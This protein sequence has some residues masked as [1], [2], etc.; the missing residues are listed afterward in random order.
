MYPK[1][2]EIMI[3]IKWHGVAKPRNGK[4]LEWRE[5]WR[6]VLGEGKAAPS[7]KDW[8]VEEEAALKNFKDEP[9]SMKETAIGC[10]KVQHKH[11]LLATFHVIC[12]VCQGKADIYGGIDGGSCPRR[13]KKW[14]RRLRERKRVKRSVRRVI[15]KII[16]LKRCET[17]CVLPHSPLMLKNQCGDIN[18]PSPRLTKKRCPLWM[19][20]KGWVALV[21]QD[22]LS[23]RRHR[24]WLLSD[25][26]FGGEISW[27]WHDGFRRKNTES[28]VDPV[29]F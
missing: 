21:W 16:F 20:R 4:V 10:L 24:G 7:V 11:K 19:C 17:F 26:V 14:M 23:R 15:F 2:L 25:W 28:F 22:T 12:H 18:D 9:I 3:L 5:K 8:S 1:R 27:F 13:E 6:K 29:H